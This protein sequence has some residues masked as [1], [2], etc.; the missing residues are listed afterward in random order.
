MWQILS[1]IK[2]TG[3]SLEMTVVRVPP[4]PASLPIHGLPEGT[5]FEVEVRKQG[6]AL[7]IRI[8]GGEETSACKWTEKNVGLQY[9]SL[10]P[11][12]LDMTG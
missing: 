11:E 7:G 5:T 10:L 8:A 1:E 6:G 3:T 12:S 2:N 4:P 9:C